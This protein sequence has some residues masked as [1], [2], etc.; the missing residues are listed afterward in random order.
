MKFEVELQMFQKG[1]I[2]MVD[3]PDQE[4]TGNIE[5]DLDK[6]F[7]YGQNDF[8]PSSTRCSVSAGDIVRYHGIRYLIEPMGFKKLNNGGAL[9]S[10]PLKKIQQLYGGNKQ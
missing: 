10:D 6:I 4:L 5:D 8:Q 3:V 9:P 7:Y 2:R 1:V